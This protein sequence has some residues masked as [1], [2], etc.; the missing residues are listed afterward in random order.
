MFFFLH[1]F[2]KGAIDK[3]V[4][5]LRCPFHTNYWN[6][7]WDYWNKYIADGYSYEIRK[8]F[9]AFY[10]VKVVLHSSHCL[11][12][13]LSCDP[14]SDPSGN[15]DPEN[16]GEDFPRGSLCCHSLAL[17]CFFL[18]LNSDCRFDTSAPRVQKDLVLL[19]KA[20]CQFFKELNIELTIWPSNSTP[21]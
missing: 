3:L 5:I 18:V 17:I 8:E 20:V 19:W 9:V 4:S 14:F 11:T 6:S 13:M 2:H 7:S 1:A 10:F 12:F 16:E 15:C 21:R